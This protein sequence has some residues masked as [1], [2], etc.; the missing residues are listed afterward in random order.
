ML[1][2]FLHA[3][4]DWQFWAVTGG[5]F[6][7]WWGL[8]ILIAWLIYL[9]TGRPL[10]AARAAAAW[11]LL[12]AVALVGTFSWFHWHEPLRM[13]LPMVASLIVLSAIWTVLTRFE[14]RA[15]SE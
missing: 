2:E 6:F 1:Q 3:I 5:S 10:A 14:P 4:R 8:G 15:E 13:I 12:V 11:A 9:S 7:V